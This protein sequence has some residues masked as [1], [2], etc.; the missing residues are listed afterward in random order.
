MNEQQARDL[1]R[2]FNTDF[3]NGK[4]VYDRFAPAFVGQTANGL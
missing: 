4:R 3:D 2:L 1:F